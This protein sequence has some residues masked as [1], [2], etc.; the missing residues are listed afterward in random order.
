MENKHENKS[1]QSGDID[2]EIIS[3]QPSVELVSIVR[4]QETSVILFETISTN[5]FN[6]S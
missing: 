4:L 5:I 2:T 3:N 6:I 1:I